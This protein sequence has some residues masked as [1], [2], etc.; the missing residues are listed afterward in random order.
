[1]NASFYLDLASRGLRMPIGADLVLREK[2][3][4][5]AI[6][7][8]G[9]RLGDLLVEAAQR[10]RSP[11]A[12]PVMDLTLEKR[13]LLAAIGMAG[14]NIDTAHFD[15]APTDAMF[16]RLEALRELPARM[17][18]NCDATRHVASQNGFV[19]I[20]MSIG[21][22]SLMTKLLADPITPVYAA[23]AGATADDDEEVRMIE[24]TLELALRMVLR[25]VEAQCHAGAKAVFIAEPAASISYFSPHQLSGPGDTFDRYAI[26]ANRRVKAMLDSF[27]VDLIFHC[28]GDL[29][30]DLVTRFASLGPRVLSLGSSRS[31]PADARLIPPDVVLYGNLPSKK[32]YSDQVITAEQVQSQAG[33]LV[34]SMKSTHHPFILGSECDVLHVPGCEHQIRS[35]VQA[36]MNA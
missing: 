34:A 25:S 8:D 33:E 24:R 4:H 21:P 16:D 22:F 28:C 6:Q 32:F 29:V 12:F 15:S 26:A 11:L 31:L 17:R 10:Y 2:A 23:G 30:D 7:H 3:D 18:V 1:M 19:P 9:R 36:M 20:G 14:A 27:G 5:E 13:A 35:K